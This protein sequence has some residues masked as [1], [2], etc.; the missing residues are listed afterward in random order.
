MLPEVVIT[1]SSKAYEALEQLIAKDSW[2]KNLD[3]DRA[4][5]L[6]RAFNTTDQ[7]MFLNDK[8]LQQSVLRYLNVSQMIRALQGFEELPLESLIP[9]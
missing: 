6:M 2:Y 1:S 5:G 9:F 7:E 4:I 3:D 8:T